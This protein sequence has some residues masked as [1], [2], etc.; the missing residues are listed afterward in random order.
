MQKTPA[1]T[2]GSKKPLVRENDAALDLS[3]EMLPEVK[4]QVVNLISV[5]RMHV[6]MST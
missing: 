2:D 5:T 1:E 3:T 6:H 4:P